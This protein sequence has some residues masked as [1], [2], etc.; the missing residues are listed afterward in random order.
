MDHLRTLFGSQHSS[1]K[2]IMKYDCSSIQDDE[3]KKNIKQLISANKTMF[4]D[5]QTLKVIFHEMIRR[6]QILNC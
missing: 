2:K 3:E 4:I 6:D 1:H 5:K